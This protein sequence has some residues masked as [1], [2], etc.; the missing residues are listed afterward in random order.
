MATGPLTLTPPPMQTRLPF[1]RQQVVC[2]TMQTL[3]TH[4]AFD[5]HEQD[6]SRKVT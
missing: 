1:V 2:K 3:C 6:G 4:R 5:M